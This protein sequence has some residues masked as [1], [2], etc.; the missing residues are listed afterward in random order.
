M[1]KCTLNLDDRLIRTKIIGYLLKVVA[2]FGRWVVFFDTPEYPDVYNGT[3]E[4]NLKA[5]PLVPIWTVKPG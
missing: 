5:I 3:M 4:W 1:L 2:H